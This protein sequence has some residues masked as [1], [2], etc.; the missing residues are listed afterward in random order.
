MRPFSREFVRAFDST[1]LLPEEL[2]EHV[3]SILNSGTL[4]ELPHL[5]Y[6]QRYRHAAFAA[7]PPAY[8]MCP[9]ALSPHTY[10][11]TL[12]HPFTI[13]SY[14]T[15]YM[16]KKHFLCI[17]SPPPYEDTPRLHFMHSRCQCW[18]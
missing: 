3:R 1:P 10:V 16:S 18:S 12:F 4:T 13:S 5:R 15:Y 17:F 14:Y 7:F 2:K 11:P 8:F 6:V 9:S